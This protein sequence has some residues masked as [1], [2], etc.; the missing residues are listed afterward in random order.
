MR[1]KLISKR[2]SFVAINLKMLRRIN[3]LTQDELSVK[4]GIKRSSIGAYEE[5][6]AEP[7]LDTLITICEYFCVPIDK[8]LKMEIMEKTKFKKGD[9]IFHPEYGEGIFSNYKGFNGHCR[10]LFIV[11]G[12]VKSEKI[13]P[14]SKLTVK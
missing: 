5:D 9:K 12:N 14:E 13:V 8:F 6:R 10:C 2:V 3:S 11:N 4:I 7:K 1:G